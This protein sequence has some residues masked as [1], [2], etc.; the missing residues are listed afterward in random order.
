M[1]EGEERVR[2]R[3]GGVLAETEV[4]D[5]NDASEYDTGHQRQQRRIAG[6]ERMRHVQ[7]RQR[8]EDGFGCE[9]HAIHNVAAAILS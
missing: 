3:E 1:N 4:V 5:M 7:G 9:R 8:R 6:F 2:G